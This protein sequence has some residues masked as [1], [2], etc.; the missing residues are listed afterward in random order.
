MDLVHATHQSFSAYKQ[1]TTVWTFIFIELF[2]TWMVYARN[3]DP[4]K[5][6]HIFFYSVRNTPT[7]GANSNLQPTN[8]TSI[9]TCKVYCEAAAAHVLAFVHDT[10]KSI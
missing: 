6:S 5:R 7:K 2:S 4:Q 8:Y 9:S 10:H 3:A 1:D